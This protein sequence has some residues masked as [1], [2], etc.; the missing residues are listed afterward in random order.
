MV[1]QTTTD[2]RDA[3]QNAWWARGG[4]ILQRQGALAALTALVLFGVL[5][6]GENFYSEYNI[7]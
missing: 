6:Y 4:S 7:Q 2:I 1:S 5:R 3:R